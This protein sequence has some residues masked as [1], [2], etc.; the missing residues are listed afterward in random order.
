MQLELR[1]YFMEKDNFLVIFRK[2]KAKFH[3]VVLGVNKKCVQFG[4]VLF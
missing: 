4:D 1:K 2:W 3:S